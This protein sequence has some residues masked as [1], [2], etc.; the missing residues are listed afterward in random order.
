MANGKKYDRELLV[1]K[2][3]LMRIKGKSTHFILDFIMENFGVCRKVAYEI[4]KDAQTY[5][6]NQTDMEYEKAFA[7][8]IHQLE[9]LYE[10]SEPKQKL[11]VRKEISKLR[12]LYAPI[13][14]EHSGEIFLAKFPGLDE[15][16]K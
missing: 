13:R 6:L 4:L 9:E 10:I 2:V 15:N 8:A 12:G 5:M 11:E 1:S 14:V 7:E 3:A 16:E